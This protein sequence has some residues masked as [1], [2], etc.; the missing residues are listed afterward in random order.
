MLLERLDQTLEWAAREEKV[1]GLL[2]LDLDQ[3]KR[4]NDTLGHTV[5]DELL[6]QAADRLVTCVRTTDLLTRGP[7]SCEQA[8]VA[9]LGGDEFTV[10]L[11]S[12]R[13]AEDAAI[14]A[15]RILENMRAPFSAGDH[16]IVVSASIGI[17]I[18]PDDGRT[19]DDLLRSADVAMYQAKNSGRDGFQFHRESMN[20]RVEKNLRTET[21]LREALAE[22][23][24]VLHYQ[25]RVDAETGEM[26][27]MEALV[28]IEHPEA[29]LVPPVEFIPVAEETGLIV[30]IGLW[31]LRTA[32]AQN[33]AWQ[34]LGFRPLNLAV[35]L[36]TQQIRRPGLIEAVESA[37]RDT[38]L[39]PKY[40]ELEIT[41][42]VF[43]E[44]ESLVG[45]TL[46][47]LREMG[48]RLAVDDFGTG[49]SSMGYLKRFPIDILKIDRSFVTNVA[50]D[51]EN[52]AIVGAIIAMSREFGLTVVAEGI[53]TPAEEKFLRAR[54]CDEFQG[55][56]FGRPMEPDDFTV[57]LTREA[58]ESR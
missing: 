48:V 33:R 49:Y 14:V 16:D 7:N 32:C 55:Y 51:S 10:V 4:I 21:L 30:P 3:F 31:V 52:A 56:R 46:R 36:S 35:N 57:C 15:R 54:G 28:R 40:L 44:K 17:A 26:T 29:G 25:P 43:L 50:A 18:S 8:P 38:G 27:G 2:F 24:F 6:K 19:A 12:I 58:S 9:R 20:A 39:D 53:E 23:R 13:Q 42:S 34:E 22:N 1:V 41:E 11:S 47:R 37:L 45:G 5:G